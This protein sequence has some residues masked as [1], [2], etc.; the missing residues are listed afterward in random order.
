M[1]RSIAI[2]ALAAGLST[3][4]PLLA[5]PAD[6]QRLATENTRLR[7][8]VAE[9]EAKL[10]AALTELD[11]LRQRLSAAEDRLSNLEPPR[12]PQYAET[13]ADPFSSP[14]ALF[15]ELV[16]LYEREL[17]PMGRETTADQRAFSEAVDRWVAEAP[18]RI[19]AERE[20]LV[21]IESVQ[22]E[23]SAPRRF[24]GLISVIDPATGHAY[25]PARR[26]PLPPRFAQRVS[27]SDQDLWVAKVTVL[28]AP[29]RNPQRDVAGVFNEPW[30][31]GPQVEFG[32]DLEW[33]DL[34][35]AEQAPADG[36]E[37]DQNR[38]A[39]RQR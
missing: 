29:A 14:T 39:G 26:M 9:L 28:A 31:I 17:A 37:G 35:P 34:Q 13:G 8:Q 23:A 21:R 16:R 18:R 30:F 20:W 15:R 24:S 38:P 5:Q 3:A 4:A 27:E 11:V 7:D 10:Q 2:L 1:R 25:G 33:R 12:P 6:A 32:F 19:R 36:A 22:R